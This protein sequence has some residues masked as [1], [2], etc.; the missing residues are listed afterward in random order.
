VPSSTGHWIN[1]LADNMMNTLVCAQLAKSWKLVG[2]LDVSRQFQ[3]CYFSFTRKR[4]A[5]MRWIGNWKRRGL[6]ESCFSDQWENS[7]LNEEVVIFSQHQVEGYPSASRVKRGHMIV[8][9][10]HPW[11]LT[12]RWL[13]ILSGRT[14]LRTFS[15]VYFTPCSRARTVLS[16]CTGQLRR[17]P[18]LLVSA[19]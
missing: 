16:V 14:K 18:A 17:G 11:S 4:R 13:F 5:S 9:F 15:I 19:K 8:V 12:N 10:P 3:W 2:C 1:L 6:N 7:V